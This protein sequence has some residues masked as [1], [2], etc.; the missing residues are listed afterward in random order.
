VLP[1][2]GAD[3]SAAGEHIL[4]RLNEYKDNLLPSE[5]TPRAANGQR[6]YAIGKMRVYFQLAGEEYEE[7]VYIF[8]HLS[9][10]IISWR[11]AKALKIL[12]THYPLPPPQPALVEPSQPALVEPSVRVTRASDS[13][14]TLDDLQ[15]AYPTVFDGR[16]RTM[17]GEEF[18]ITLTADAKPFCV[19]TPRSIPF[20]YRDKLK[21]E[22]EVLQ[23]QQIITPVTE[24]T[25][26]CAPIVVTPKKN[27]D[28]IRMCVDLSHLNRFVVRERYQSL[29]PAQAIADIA[30][31]E[32]KYFTVID[33]LKGY[34]QCPLDEQS[35][36]LTTFI[37]PFGRFKY[38]R[39]PY[40]ISSISEHYNRRMSEAFTGLSGFR[41]VVDD[42]V[43]YDGNLSDHIAHVK[44]F[45][46][47]CA[48]QHI[49][50]NAEKCRFFQTKTTFAG[51]LLSDQGYQIDPVITEAIWKYPVPT[52]RTELRSFIG[53]VN[54]LSSSTNAVA[55][56]LTPFRA[57]LSTKNE[58]T[59]SPCH[60]TAFEAAKKS[61][62]T[63]PTLSYFDL[64]KP[65]RLSTDASRQGLGYVLQQLHG[66]TWSL[67]QA[68]SRF[69]SDAE[70]RYAII[71]LELLAVA[72]AVTKCRIFLAGL[73][74]F[75]V[76]T[77][78]NPLISILN[79][80]RLDEIENP[81]LQRLKS[82][83]MGYNL[84][85]KWI[86]GKGNNA[87]DALSRNPVLDPEWNDT[88][89]EYDQQKHPELS[90][91][92]IRLL[93]SDQYESTRLHN[94]REEAAK[95]QEYQQLHRFITQ[96]FPDHRTQLPE[97][98]RRYWGI[99]EHLTLDDGLI[100]YG[101]RLLIP[102]SMRRMVLANLHESH[103][104]SVRTKERARLSLYWPGIDNDIDNLVTSCKQCQDHLP[105]NCKEPIISKP[106]PSRPFQQIAVDFC[107]YGGH[108][109]LVTVDCLTDWPEI[110]PMQTNTSTQRLIQSLTELFCRTSVPDILW[111]DGGPQFTSTHFNSF[112]TQWG[113]EHRMSS[114]HYPQSNGKVEATIKSMKK[115]IA[116]SWGNRSLN[117]GVMC[118]ALLQYR[119]TPSRKDGQSP[120]QKLYSRPIQDTLPAHRRSFAPEW[121]RSTLE[122]EQLA[123]HTLT[124]TE[125]SY[126]RH[127]R[128]LQE[129][130]V[131]STVALQNPRTKLWDIY[132]SVVNVSPHRRYSVKTRSGRVLVR[133]RK[134]LRLRTPASTITSASGSL[135]PNPTLQSAETVQHSRCT[136]DPP[137]EPQPPAR[138]FQTPPQ[139]LRRSE[140]ASRPP[141][142]L[143]EDPQWP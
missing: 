17:E 80:R 109:F 71:E 105:S 34:H 59:W 73:Q 26:W 82:R 74:H 44:Q 132:G 30:A 48:D 93:H 50:L 45:L 76:V 25:E 67:V 56:L 62:T 115:I 104:G 96:G 28:K 31:S 135:Q 9:G 143:I 92:E 36:P 141:Q 75:T 85:A 43:I 54:Q 69:L 95:D 138:Q 3:I 58:F 19:T 70:S 103:Q 107:S 2:S 4:A 131:G 129:I 126:N 52:N 102:V 81:R 40:G 22:L 99:R 1:D 128:N 8:P 47:R 113:F 117:L 35:Q 37:T 63:Q 78:H 94:L 18:H 42:F 14:P 120:A 68:G 106:K 66:D 87:P 38:L 61:L 83:L 12:S 91:T 88:L 33:A 21:A 130:Y 86:K 77:D 118:R 136:Q 24:A 57:L 90:I 7:D 20:A 142:R 121:Q 27:S 53:L 15:Q 122:A 108:Q 49:A 100:V 97:A 123:E 116:S 124:Q 79:N 46:Q 133:N 16:I 11:A 29:T 119:N 84:T 125:E 60:D 55:S 65:T 89:A 64:T 5:F 41:R 112:A 140:R 13:L 139:D 127:A 72:W 134:F 39:A 6:M 23:A 98:C 32:A 110:I 137:R 114:P 51:F 111:S 10:V 101:C